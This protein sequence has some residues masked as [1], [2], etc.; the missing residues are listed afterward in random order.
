MSP[1]SRSKVHPASLPR[2]AVT[3]T[4]EV[5]TVQE[6]PVLLSSVGDDPSEPSG[7]DG[8]PPL[9]ND[10]ECQECRQT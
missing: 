2:I 4:A 10:S 1:E 8:P 3:G 5:L 9:H 7:P 6:G